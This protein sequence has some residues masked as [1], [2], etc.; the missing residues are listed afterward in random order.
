MSRLLSW[1][2]S[3]Q[4]WRHRRAFEAAA[5]RPAEAQARVLRA[6][7]EANAATAFGR[8]HGFASLRTPGEYARRVPIRDYEALRGYVARLLAG[9]PG[10][11]TAEPPLMFATT[12][13]TTGEPKFIPV[14]ATSAR[15]TADLMRLWTVHALRD[16]GRMLD[17]RVLTLVGPPRAA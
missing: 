17:R 16:H 1:A 13:G 3:A 14:T 9:E 11:L 4:Q 7:L 5:A 6:L 15:Q 8:D 2:L 12:S 10:V